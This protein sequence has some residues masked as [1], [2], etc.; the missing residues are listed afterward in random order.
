[1]HYFLSATCPRDLILMSRPY[2]SPY[3]GKILIGSR[4]LSPQNDKIKVENYTKKIRISST[5]EVESR[6]C[7]F[8]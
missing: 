4:R 1:M 2:K 5:I 6:F 7:L 8:T 3:N